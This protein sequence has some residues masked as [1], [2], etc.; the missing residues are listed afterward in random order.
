M[1]PDS[2]AGAQGLAVFRMQIAYPCTKYI[3]EKHYVLVR[4]TC[5]AVYLA[6]QHLGLELKILHSEPHF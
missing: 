4:C 6:G 3:Q 1:F 5:S 2:P